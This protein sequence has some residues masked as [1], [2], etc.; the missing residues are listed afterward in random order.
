MAAI[1]DHTTRSGYRVW[2]KGPATDHTWQQ[3][4][5]DPNAHD[6]PA[7]IAYLTAAPPP[8]ATTPSTASPRTP[9]PA[10]PPTA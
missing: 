5:I 10:S 4:A 8:T 9:A 3:T 1:A 6:R 7:T 2:Q